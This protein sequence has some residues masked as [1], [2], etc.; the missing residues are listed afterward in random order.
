MK[1]LYSAVVLAGIF[2]LGVL[3][4]HDGQLFQNKSYAFV[5]YADQ[6]S[7]SLNNNNVIGVN[8]NGKSIFQV[9]D[10]CELRPHPQ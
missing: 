6:F 5:N 1:K 2:W 10:F 4:A 9:K 3:I 7:I 8:R